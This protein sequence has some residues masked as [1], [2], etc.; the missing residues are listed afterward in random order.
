MLGLL[1]DHRLRVPTGFPR[2]GL[3]VYLLG[4]TLAEL[5][6]SEFAEAVLGVVAGQPPR[7]DLE[8]EAGAPAAPASSGGRDAAR[9]RPRLRRRRDRDRARRVGD[10]GRARVRRDRSGRPA[11]PRRALQ[12]ICIARGRERG[13]RA[14]GTSGRARGRA[15]R[16]D[17]EDRGDGRPAG[18]VRRA[19]SRPP[20][21]SCA[22]PTRRRSRAFW[23]SPSEVR[24]GARGRHVRLSGYAGPRGAPRDATWGDRRPGNGCSTRP[25]IP[26]TRW[27]PGA[28]APGGRRPVACRARR[29]QP[30]HGRV[31]RARPGHDGRPL[32]RD[33]GPADE[34]FPEATHVIADL[35]ELTRALGF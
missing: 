14:R 31:R 4:E 33:R 17:R 11:A 32:H 24:A 7:L 12:R 5:G 21:T 23:A 27:P 8:R 6:G 35:A 13:A 28:R 20:S 34:R 10:R 26:P 18:G 30:P 3:A 1:A 2:P 15:R 19:S 9:E 16:P 29:R 22:R 25:R